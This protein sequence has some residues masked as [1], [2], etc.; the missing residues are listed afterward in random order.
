[1][2]KQKFFLAVFFMGTFFAANAQV[3]D[4]TVNPITIIFSGRADVSAEYGVSKD[5]GVE[6]I[7]S[8]LTPNN[9]ILDAIGYDEGK[10]LGLA[11]LGKY[12]FNPSEDGLDRFNVGA[13]TNYKTIALTADADANESIPDGSRKALS[14]GIYLGYKSVSKRNIVFDIGF[15]VGRYF[16]NNYEEASTG[17]KIDASDIPFLGTD[18][19]SKIAVGYRF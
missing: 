2:L 17:E 12:Y 5:F 11:A 15:G 10:G 16:F 3:V 1:M 6:G 19:F 18:L 14:A 13:Y 4:V 7:A 8:Y 9:L